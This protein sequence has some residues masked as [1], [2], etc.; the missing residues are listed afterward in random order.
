MRRTLILVAV[1]EAAYVLGSLIAGGRPPL[2][3]LL[4]WPCVCTIAISAG[5][6]LRSRR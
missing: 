6:W 2:L 1:S 4:L 3:G 5:L